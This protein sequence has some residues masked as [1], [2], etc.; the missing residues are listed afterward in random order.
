MTV[1]KI[2]FIDSFKLYIETLNSPTWI[3]PYIILINI[4]FFPNCLKLLKNRQNLSNCLITVIGQFCNLLLTT[5]TNLLL[6]EHWTTRDI[7]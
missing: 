1:T 2:V 4:F 7:G 5:F 3:F 6:F